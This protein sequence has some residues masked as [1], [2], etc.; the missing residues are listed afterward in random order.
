MLEITTFGLMVLALIAGTLARDL[1]RAGRDRTR[2]SHMDSLVVEFT[3]QPLPLLVD[4]LGSPYEVAE[5][6][7]GRSLHIWKSPPNERLPK[8]SGLLTMIATVEEGGTISR[9]EWHEV[10]EI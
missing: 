3:D 1:W 2:A 6:V 4:F 8:G 9:I 7:S 5:G 10:K